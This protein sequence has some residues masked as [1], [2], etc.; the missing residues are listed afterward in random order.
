MHLTQIKAPTTN[1]LIEAYLGIFL[2]IYRGYLAWMSNRY[3]LSWRRNTHQLHGVQSVED[4]HA[5]D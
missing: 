1:D 3:A 4:T 2:D 5:K